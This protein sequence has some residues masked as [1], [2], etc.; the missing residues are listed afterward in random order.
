[1]PDIH[2][3]KPRPVVL[4][5]THVRLEPLDM[6]HLDDLYEFGC[7]E[8][9]WRYIPSPAFIERD[10]ARR[11]IEDSITEM[12]NLRNIVFAIIDL[13]TGRA[14]GSTRFLTISPKD[15]GLEIGYTWL[16]RPFRR[17]AIN[18]E[19][20]L[21]L[22]THAFED[23]GA[24]RMQYKTDQRNEGSQRAIERIGATFEGAL[25]NHM[26]MTDGFHRT[27]MYYSVT[28]E[29]WPAVKAHLRKLLDR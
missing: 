28:F 11:W 21:L 16:G 25:R 12:T 29:E 22:M 27:S 10:D 6:K 8:D 4:E 5:G 1:M 23:L 18:T 15:R 24:I 26:I 9:V 20:K 2:E 13:K 14:A 19:C 17:T 3:F 7:D